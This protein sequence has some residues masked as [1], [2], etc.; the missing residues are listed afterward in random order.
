VRLGGR[1]DPAKPE[2]PADFAEYRRRAQ[3]S[4]FSLRHSPLLPPTFSR[5]HFHI[6]LSVNFGHYTGQ[7]N[8]IFFCLPEVF[9][10]PQNVKCV[11]DPPTRN[12]LGS[13]QRSFR[14]PSRLGR[15]HP[16][17]TLTSTPL[18][19]RFSRFRCSLVRA[20]GASNLAPWALAT[21]LLNPRSPP[22]L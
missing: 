12:P 16:S 5:Y 4:Q 7:T 22:L 10:D 6:N 3:L 11:S 1:V 9:C 8:R 14:P 13:S 17:Q 19:P 21:R 15:G 20:F 18:V 2:I